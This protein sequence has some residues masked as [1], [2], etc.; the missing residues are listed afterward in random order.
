MIMARTSKKN[1]KN[2]KQDRRVQQ[3]LDMLAEYRQAH[4]S[5]EIDAHRENVVSIQIRII[6]PDF[7]GVDWIDRERDIWPILEKLPEDVRAD[8]TLLLLL[9]PAETKTSPANMEYEDPIPSPMPRL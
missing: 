2:K 5:A 8:I 9:T 1:S 4:P 6:D 7:E 3:I